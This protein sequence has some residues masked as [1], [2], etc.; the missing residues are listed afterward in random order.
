VGGLYEGL[1]DHMVNAPAP[2]EL[3]PEEAGVYL[4]E[5]R[6]KLRVLITKSINVYERTLEAA[7]RIGAR[8][9]FVDKTRESL[10]KM[11]DVLLT[12][13][14]E[15]EAEAAAAAAAA[16]AARARSQGK[17][18]PEKKAPPRGGKKTPRTERPTSPPART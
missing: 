13:T 15:D 9:H 3:T 7:E 4:S 1:Y 14:Q 18:G 17:P 10:R 2:R 6:K 12:Q 16:E 8:S 5:L 11:K